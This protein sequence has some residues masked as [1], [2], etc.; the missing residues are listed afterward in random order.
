MSDKTK[1][2]LADI[3]KVEQDL[4]REF[5]LFGKLKKQ[6][7]KAIKCRDENS[8]DGDTPALVDT[9][10]K[11]ALRI[12]R[13]TFGEE[14][15]LRR[16]VK[17]LRK[18]NELIPDITKEAAGTPQAKKIKA[19]LE[20]V[21][22][23]NN[24]L[25]KI[26]SNGGQIEEELQDFQKHPEKYESSFQI[27]SILEDVL[28]DVQAEEVELKKLKVLVH[29]SKHLKETIAEDYFDNLIH[30]TLNILEM[31]HHLPS[32]EEFSPDDA[33]DQFFHFLSAQP[34][35]K[36]EL[37][38]LVPSDSK[39]LLLLKKGKELGLWDCDYGLEEPIDYQMRDS[40]V[41]RIL[42]TRGNIGP[43]H[44]VTL[45]YFETTV[46]FQVLPPQMEVKLK[47]LKGF[48]RD[49]KNHRPKYREFPRETRWNLG[50]P[51]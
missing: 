47:Q 49:R 6:L 26:G 12:L 21:E 20:K 10:M 14:A 50:V 23:Y 11:S 37:H 38:L 33:H 24:L 34:R 4:M 3:D 8:W 30:E 43:G 13:G 16:E 1:K 39:A 40:S 25:V 29:D 17:D 42:A 36:K 2:V 27:E 44:S 51:T 18:L 35:K 31:L 48:L 9:A 46:S 41:E 19:V 45:D 15:N 32:V 22:I 5:Y 28:K 7:Q